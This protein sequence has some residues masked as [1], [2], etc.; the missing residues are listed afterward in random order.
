MSALDWNRCPLSLEYAA[1]IVSRGTLDKSDRKVRE[2]LAESSDLLAAIRLPDCAFAKR[3]LTRV[4]TDILFLQRRGDH[5]PSSDTAGWL[6]TAPFSTAH[7]QVEINEYF[8]AHPAMILGQMVPDAGRYGDPVCRL[9]KPD[10]LPDRLA[11]AIRHLPANCYQPAQSVKPQTNTT[12]PHDD[13]EILS[14]L[15]DFSYAAMPDGKIARRENNALVR[16]TGLGDKRVGRINGL[17]RVRDAARAYLSA[18][19]RDIDDSALESTRDLLNQTYDRFMARH[20]PINLRANQLALADDP[21]LPFLLAL[22]DFDAATQKASKTPF[23]FQRTLDVQTTVTRA[24]TAADALIYSLREKGK[25]DLA[26]MSGLTGRSTETLMSE[27]AGQLFLNPQSGQWE[28]ADTYL[29]GNVVQKLR[30]AQ[31]SKRPELAANVAALQAVQ[32]SPLGPGEIRIRL[33][34]P[35]IPPETIQAFVEDLL[36]R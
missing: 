31:A 1:V 24:D 27:L 21:D 12:K 7:G 29:S 16:L 20:G 22:E 35:W 11:A 6:G 4:T 36:C 8:A 26:Y 2:K 25:V 13:L 10:E 5:R 9:E 30:A 19:G 33:G 14:R 17:L 18:Q 3:A 28:T 23:F 15:K 32:P 34:A